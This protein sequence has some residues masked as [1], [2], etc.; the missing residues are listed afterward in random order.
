MTYINDLI[1]VKKRIITI[2]FR[3]KIIKK[4]IYIF[5]KQQ[6]QQK[7]KKPRENFTDI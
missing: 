2:S 5:T 7:K 6:Q 1:V 3:F 4:Y